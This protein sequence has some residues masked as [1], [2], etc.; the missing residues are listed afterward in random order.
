MRLLIVTILV[1]MLA[2]TLD[3]AMGAETTSTGLRSGARRQLK[4]NNDATSESDDNTTTERT[5]QRGRTP[6]KETND[7]RF[8][9][10]Q[11]RM[12]SSHQADMEAAHVD[13]DTTES[14]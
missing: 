1:F 9:A 8:A 10:L 13:T 7:S 2:M 5:L 3:V 11:A 4:N 14:P 6:T 12:K